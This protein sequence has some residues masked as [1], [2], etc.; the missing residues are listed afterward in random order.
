MCKVLWRAKKKLLYLGGI[1]IGNVLWLFPVFRLGVF[2]IINLL[3]VIPILWFLGFG[4]L[5]LF[6]GKEVPVLLQ[7]SGFGLLV[8]NQDFVGSIRVDNECV[9]VGE[10]VILA[11]DLLLG[12]QVVALVVEDDMHSLGAGAANV[13]A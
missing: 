8:I 7:S 2:G 6:G 9:Q 12:Q 13:G 11:T 3:P 1:G 5:D 4:I 10:D